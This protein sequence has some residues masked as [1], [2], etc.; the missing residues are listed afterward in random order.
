MLLIGTLI[1]CCHQTSII[2]AILQR[3]KGRE[4]LIEVKKVIGMER[5]K[6]KIRKRGRHRERPRETRV[7]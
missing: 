2:I 1:A 4:R 3:K 6:G 5:E 7:M